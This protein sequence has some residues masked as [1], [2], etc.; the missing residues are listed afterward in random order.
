MKRRYTII[1][2]STI[3]AAFSFWM[4]AVKWVPFGG[5]KISPSLGLGE[6]RE[7]YFRVLAQH[8]VGSPER[9]LVEALHRQ[10]FQI[11]RLSHPFESAA[12][13][14]TGG[15]CTREWSVLWWTNKTDRITDITSR[16]DYEC[17]VP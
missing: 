2:I 7:F 8:P 14:R 16:L 9:A 12:F 11:Q 17:P 6:Q 1:G 10:G 5:Y 15:L 13:V 4:L 3:A